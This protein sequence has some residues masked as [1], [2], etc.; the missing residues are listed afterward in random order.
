MAAEQQ[1]LP[2][3][4]PGLEHNLPTALARS[5]GQLFDSG[6]KI[7]G[8]SP[9]SQRPSTHCIA[10]HSPGPGQHAPQPIPSSEH[11]PPIVLVTHH[12]KEI[13]PAFTH[14]L[15]LKSGRVVVAGARQKV[16]TSKTMSETFNARLRLGRTGRRL[17]LDVVHA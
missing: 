9:A 5:A 2:Q 14:A 10:G 4:A 16:L 15:M 7:G 3:R 8:Q 6:H 17:R 12:V 11:G 1:A 13:T